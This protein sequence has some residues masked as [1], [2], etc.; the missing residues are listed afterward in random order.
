M[1]SLNHNDRRNPAE[2]WNGVRLVHCFSTKEGP[3]FWHA[4]AI[5]SRCVSRHADG[6]TYKGHVGK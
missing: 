6:Y 2:E 3:N 1:T 5:T 4:V